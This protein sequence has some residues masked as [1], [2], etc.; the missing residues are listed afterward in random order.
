MVA[1]HLQNRGKIEH[2]TITVIKQFVY[3]NQLLVAYFSSY[4][5]LNLMQKAQVMEIMK[6]TRVNHLG[7][8]VVTQT[9]GANTV[10]IRTPAVRIRKNVE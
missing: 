8:L 4:V 3:Y 6:R 2:Q 1:K 9:R 7:I 10:A 5:Y